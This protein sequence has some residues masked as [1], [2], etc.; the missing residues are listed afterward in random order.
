MAGTTTH[1]FSV[2]KGVAHDLQMNLDIVVAMKCDD[3]HINVQDASGD[4]IMASEMLKKDS[5]RWMLWTSAEGGGL[6]LVEGRKGKEVR[7]AREK[8]QQREQSG[9][10]KEWLR[11]QAEQYRREEDVHEYL[12]KAR[13]RHLFKGTPRM[14]RGEEGDACRVYG[15][16]EGNKVQGDFH[17]TARGHGYMEFGEHLDHQSMCHSSLPSRDS[18]TVTL[19]HSLTCA[20]QHSTSPTTSTSSPSDPTSPTSTTPSTQPTAPQQ[21][22]STNTSTSSA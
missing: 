1:S 22:T 12:S 11:Q 18:V 10:E 9:G 19:Q 4:R 21:T 15:S 3:L 5:T 2:E 6:G 20:R 7:K 17:I 14:R 13:G 16:L 8:E